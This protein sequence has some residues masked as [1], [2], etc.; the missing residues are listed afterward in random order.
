M[1]TILIDDLI[2]EGIVNPKL[3]STGL[4]TEF[5]SESGLSNNDS[6]EISIVEKASLNLFLRAGGSGLNFR[7]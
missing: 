4:F 7:A 5:M 2:N 6:I 3:I 1:I